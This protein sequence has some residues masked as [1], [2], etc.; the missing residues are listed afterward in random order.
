MGK[1]IK[2]KSPRLVGFDYDSAG[3]YFV[4]LCTKD[5]KC[6]LSRI[7]LENIRAEEIVGTG[8]P[9]CP[10]TCL[11]PCGKIADKYIRQLN[12]F[13]PH[14]FVDNFVIMPNHIHILLV[15]EELGQSR[16]PVP[17]CN[18][19]N[20]GGQ[21]R[22]PVPTRANT[23]LSQFISTF[24]RFCNKEY[25]QNIWQSRSFDRV[26]R[27]EEEYKKIWNYIESNPSKWSEDKY[28][29]G[30]SGMPV[31]TEKGDNNG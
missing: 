15:I 22:T 4:T 27:T 29:N 26:I 20:D 14:I 10:K 13:Y 9:D 5:M 30:S 12:D 31:P 24:K 19:A 2:R 1:F 6:L 11:T 28:N 16:T 23:P 17:T 18:S 21:S 3:A 25:G 7:E 8:V